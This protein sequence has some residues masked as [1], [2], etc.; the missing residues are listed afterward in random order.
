[1]K[2][3]FLPSFI[4]SLIQYPSPVSWHIHQMACRLHHTNSS[5]LHQQQT[6]AAPPHGQPTSD[7]AASTSHQP[8]HRTRL[9]PKETNHL[10][11][12]TTLPASVQPPTLAVEDK[13]L[14]LQAIQQPSSSTPSHHRLLAKLSDLEILTKRE[15]Q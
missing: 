7:E 10:V 4:P 5:N 9:H 13:E 3:T 15:H 11:A 12:Q 6:V 2:A 1:M 14:I 8:L